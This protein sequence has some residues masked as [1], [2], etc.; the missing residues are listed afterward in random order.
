M[1]KITDPNPHL[2]ILEGDGDVKKQ[3]A[4]QAKRALEMVQRRN[5][6]PPQTAEQ[7]EAER[8]Q[9]ESNAYASDNALYAAARS[10]SASFLVIPLDGTK[11]LVKPT[12]ATRDARELFLWWDRWPDANPGILLGRIGGVFA[13]RVEDNKAWE[14]LWEMSAVPMHDPDTD[15][16]WTAYRH[17]GGGRVRLLAP[18]QPFT[19]RSRSGWGRE[20]L[21][22]ARDFEREDRNR[23]P[24]TG[25]LVYSYPS[26]QSG[27]DAFN[28]PSRAIA[29][30]IRLLGEGD[31]LPWDGSILEG[32]MK[33][34]RLRHALLRRRYGSLRRS[35]SLE[36]VRS[37]PPL[38]KRTRP[39]YGP[40]TPTT[41]A[42]L[43]RRGKRASEPIKPRLPNVSEPKRR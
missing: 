17:L 7:I 8:F 12:D 40:M 31:V 29:S 10:T 19:T 32:G 42:L 3:I 33:F 28:Y 27:M 4:E 38:V 15:K 1:P 20:W 30:G 14:L 21:Q 36:A 35:A 23:H 24:E 11:P 34:T 16:K 18:S 25:F 2:S 43:R 13:I 9:Y 26:V 39:P 22:F 41:W 5:E 37:W 6:L